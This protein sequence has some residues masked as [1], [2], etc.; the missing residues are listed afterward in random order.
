MT[1]AHQYIF[2]AVMLGHDALDGF[3]SRQ[4]KFIEVEDFRNGLL[5]VL[6]QA[7]Q[8]TL[9]CLYGSQGRRAENPLWHELVFQEFVSQQDRCALSS[10]VQWPLFI[11][12][13]AIVP[14]ALSVP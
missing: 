7:L 2:I 14:I 3:R 12:Y 4:V 6:T 8:D 11:S 10:S 1:D 5:A 9:E 13:G